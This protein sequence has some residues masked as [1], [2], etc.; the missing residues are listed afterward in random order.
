LHTIRARILRRLARHDLGI[1]ADGSRADP[2]AEESPVLA[3]LSRAS[4]QGRVALGPRAGARVRGLGRDPE[5]G[6]SRRADRATPIST[7]S[8]FMA[9]SRWPR[10]IARDW[11]SSAATCDAGRPHRGLPGCCF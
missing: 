2:V 10:G 5:A 9:M 4:V 7:G 3:G 6:G 1:D 11:N 8:T